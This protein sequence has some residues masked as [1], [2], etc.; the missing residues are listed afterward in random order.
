VKL[1]RTGES[2]IDATNVTVVNASS[3][4]CTFDLTNKRP[5]PWDVVVI[6]PSATPVS[7]VGVFQVV[8]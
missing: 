3:I 5:G 2:D 6:N 7:K 1:K 8:P 4:T